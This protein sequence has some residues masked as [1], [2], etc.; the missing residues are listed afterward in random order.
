V[1]AAAVGSLEILRLRFPPASAHGVI[2]PPKPYL[3]VVI[4]GAVH[5]SFRRSSSTLSRGSLM[6]IPAGAAHSSVFAGDGCQVVIIRPAGEEGQRLLPTQRAC[7]SVAAE[8]SALLGWRI[9]KE[10]ACR[11]ACSPLA[12]EGLALELLACAGRADTG[13]GDRDTGWLDSVLDR[14]HESTPHSVSL[15]ELGAAVGRHPA[16]VARA[17]R[18]AHGVSVA[19]Y[20]R[21][22]RLEWATVA[23]ATTDDPIARIAL[24]AG[25]ADQSHF[26][27]AFGRHHGVT[28]AR[29]RELV[30]S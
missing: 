16:H 1:T 5:K 15:H 10:L 22:L 27:R 21:T 12:L 28:P 11:D 17:F 7:T 29:Y 30:R 4:D 24:D 18:R 6:S 23:V 8:A 26:T 9:A 20:A 19:A 3:A 2:D 14:L 13:G 25:F